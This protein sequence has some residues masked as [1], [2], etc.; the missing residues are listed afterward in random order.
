VKDEQEILDLKN[1]VKSISA[2]ADIE[3]ELLKG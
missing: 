1:T 2:Q 3:N